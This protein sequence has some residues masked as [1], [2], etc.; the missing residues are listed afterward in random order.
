MRDEIVKDMCHMTHDINTNFRMLSDDMRKVASEIRMMDRRI[1][2][3][4]AKH[5]EDYH[6]SLK[7]LKNHDCPDCQSYQDCEIFHEN[8]EN[9]I[10][11][12]PIYNNNDNNIPRL[13]LP[14]R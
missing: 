12:F 6:L 8:G 4:E 14:H 1:Y 5:K 9:P 10:S 2:Q 13:R 7:Y 3:M 11:D